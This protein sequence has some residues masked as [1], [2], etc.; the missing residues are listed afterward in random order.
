MRQDLKKILKVMEIDIW[1]TRS[2]N[3][4]KNNNSRLKTEPSVT[5]SSNSS[6][7]PNQ[8]KQWEKLRREVATCTRCPLHKTRTNTVFG[9]GNIHA[10]LMFIGE[11]PGAQEDI[12][13]EPFVGRAGQ[14]LTSMLHAIGFSRDDI[15]I[16]NILKSRPPNNRDPL[17]EEVAACTPFLTQQ[18]ALIQPKLLVTLGRIASHFLLNTN[19]S[20]GSLRG[21][22]FEYGSTKIP[23]LATYHPA[24]L[25]RS[26]L[27]KA[28]AY[29]DLCL[30]K[31]TLKTLT[32]EQRVSA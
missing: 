14:L 24:F 13:G 10:D 31:K 18:I 28:N 5:L 29:E 30:I 6:A 23:L 15:Y 26:P 22:Q 27:N 25:L 12:Q 7:L 19:A 20:L 11:A 16:A 3:M 1:E 4:K 8:N 9:T 21:K 2:D 17:P 32:R